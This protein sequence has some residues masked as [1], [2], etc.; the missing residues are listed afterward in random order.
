MLERLKI[1]RR[2]LLALGVLFSLFPIASAV[3][4]AQSQPDTGGVMVGRLDG[5]VDPVSARILRGWL[6]DAHEAGTQLFV[7]ELD[8][9]GG[10]LESMREMVGDILDSPVPI[11][12]LV[13]PSGS[14]AASAGTFLVASAHVAAMSPGTTIGAASPVGAGGEELPETIKAKTTQDVAAL[15]RSI[16]NQRDRNSEALVKTITEASSYSEVEALELDILDLLAINVSDLLDQMDGME[17]SVQGSVVTLET[18][19]LAVQRAEVS[20]VQRVLQFLANP[21]LVFILIALGAI[22]ILLEIFIPGGWVAGILGAGLLILA[23]LGLGS[24][25]VNWIGLVLIGAGLVLFFV[26]LQ[27]PGWGGFGLAG[28]ISFILGGF[29][30]F[31]DTS[32]PGLPAPDVRV[33]YGVLGVTAAFM[34]LSLAGLWYFSRKARGITVV[35][36][37]SQIVG[38]VGTV[39]RTLEPRG[40]VYAAGELWTAES[41]SGESIEVGESVVVTD[42]DGVI[43][44]VRKEE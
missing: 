22:L 36:R 7:L 27:A 5:A 26:E 44:T 13:T 17:V 25:P 28:G 37:E 31:G 18:G 6:S 16:A 11:A 39:R 23:F 33:G 8:T 38:Q 24:L 29:F 9:P 40:T 15:L 14:R 1:L 4:S 2:A 20:P 42:M 34:A 30:L 35:S 32:V 10:D 12:V 43:L 21:T 19:G 41:L 3:I